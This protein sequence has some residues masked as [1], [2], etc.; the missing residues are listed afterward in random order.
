MSWACCVYLRVYYT[1]SSNIIS[2]TQCPSSVA[3]TSFPSLIFPETWLTLSLLPRNGCRR[4]GRERRSREREAEAGREE[5][6]R[7]EKGRN[8]KREGGGRD[9]CTHTYSLYA[10]ITV[11][12]NS[13][14]SHVSFYLHSCVCSTLK[15]DGIVWFV[16]MELMEQKKTTVKMT[17]KSI[18]TLQIFIKRTVCSFCH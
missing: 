9:R 18:A 5:R 13:V 3:N 12:K 16:L 6:V 11:E 4:G 2:L 14:V 17:L 7:K 15:Q 1:T 8:W 10:A